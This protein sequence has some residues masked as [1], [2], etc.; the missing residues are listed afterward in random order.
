M[1]ATEYASWGDVQ[2]RA[3]RW[4]NLFTVEGKHPNIADVEQLLVNVN[5]EI[6]AALRARGHDPAALTPD[7]RSAFTDLS[8][9]AALARALVAVPDSPDELKALIAR[10]DRIEKTG[11]A[12]LYSGGFA[13]LAELEATGG[14]SAGTFWGDEPDYGTAAQVEVELETTPAGHLPAFAR[15]QEM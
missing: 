14:T 10:A 1:A 3:G 9:Y 6:D 4:V 5:A 12:G 11:F 15:D 7:R 2:A 8:A 13:V